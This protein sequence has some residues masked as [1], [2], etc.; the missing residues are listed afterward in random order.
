[1]SL[2][3]ASQNRVSNFTFTNSRS[4]GGGIGAGSVVITSIIITDSNFNNLD[5]TA[6]ATTN[7]YIRI[8]GT[9]FSSSANVFVS[10]SKV[11]SNNVTYVNSTELRVALPTASGYGNTNIFVFNPDNSGAIW[12]PGLLISGTPDF[13]QQSY[14]TS[15]PLSVS[16]QLLATGDVPLTY[17]LQSGSTLPAGL[18]ISSSG[19][20]S[21]S[22]VDGVYQFTVVVSDA[23]LQS[24]QSTITLTVTSTDE[25]FNRTVLAINADTD[26]FVRDASNNNF[27]ITVNGDTKPY[28]FSPYNTNWSNLFDGTG[29][30]LSIAANSSINL[31]TGDFTVEAWI[32]A[33]VATQQQYGC[34]LANHV[35]NGWYVAFN[36]SNQI[37]WSNHTTVAATSST[38][39]TPFKWI[40]VAVTRSGTSLKIFQDGVEVASATNSTAYGDSAAALLVGQNGTGN[41]FTGYVSNAR[42]LKGT[43]LYTSAFTPPAQQLTAITNTSV[44]TCQSNR[45]IDNSTNNLAITKYGDTKVTTFGPF[46]ETDTTTGSGYFDGTGDY[47]TLLNNSAFDLGSGDATIEA[48]IY[49]TTSGQTCG[50]FDKRSSGANYSQFPQI[51]LTSGAFIAYVSYTGSS[52]AGTIN[53]AT[54]T[55]N[56][57]THVAFVRNGNTWTLYVNGSVSGTPFTAAGSVYTSTDSLVIGAS[58][59]AG[60]NPFTGYITNARIIKGTAVYTSAFTPP[61]APLTVIANTSLLTLQNRQPVNNHTFIDQSG[62]N[63]I[64]TKSG[65][66]SQGS[67]SPYSPAG[68]SNYFDGSGDYLTTSSATLMDVTSASQTFTIETWIYP[69]GINT[70]GP[71]NYRFTSI[72]SKGVV[73]LSFGYTSTG[74]LRWYT[75]NG[76][77]NYINSPSGT[78]QNNTWQHVAI[79]SNSGAITLYVNGV[80][81]ATGSLVA[82]NGGTGVSPKIGAGD[83]AAAADFLKGY[84]SNLRVTSSAVYTSAF[85]PSI[86]PLTAITNTS[87][88]TCQSNRLID[89]STNNF[90]LTRNGDVR[91]ANFSPF[92]P[93]AIYS[94]TTHGGSAYFDGSDYLQT[95]STDSGLIRTGPF[96]IE[97]WVYPLS[98]NTNLLSRFYWQTGDNGGWTLSTNSSGFVTFSYSTGA[99]N[100]LG[101]VTATTN[102]VVI[103]QW[104]HIAVTRDT[105]NTLRIFVNGNS[106][107]TPITLAQ[108]LDTVAVQQ[109]AVQS[110]TFRVAVSG[111]GDGALS[112]YYTGYISSVKIQTGVAKYTANSIPALQTFSNESGIN[113]LSNMNTI[114]IFDN[115]SRN[116]IETVGDAKI[117]TDIKKYG[118]GS[119]YFD[120]TGD[121]LVLTGNVDNFVFGVGDFTIEFWLYLNANQ[122]SIVYDQRASGAQGLYPELYINTNSIRFYTNSADRIVGATLNNQQWY[123][124]ALA[125]SG[126][127]TKLFVNG[128]QSGSTYTDSNNYINGTNR[129]V[130]GASASSLGSDP[131]NGYIDD[132]R[133]TKGVARYTTNFNA[134]TSTFLTQ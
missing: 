17:Q 126:T 60:V 59:T 94:P 11:I 90:T 110:R 31:G 15:T 7:S 38:A 100:T 118:T 85:T 39:I 66:P 134:P 115:S 45:L 131:F 113:Y 114:G 88:L 83:T 104:N 34:I 125:R 61:T 89:N 43:A 91:V 73:Y 3:T 23:Q 14:T 53:G 111:L 121:Y 67:F 48:W 98:L 128:T 47:L 22:T 51:A 25:Y 120:G 106:A 69:S 56:A 41:Y 108:S 18:T 26:T 101:G 12:A 84:V 46:T 65:N 28:A 79:V 123:H 116:F 9:G 72:L 74:V 81:V 102:P 19:L 1:M 107:V 54:P 63:N 62:L 13:L 10:G 35:T 20:I 80:S 44:L 99:W 117:R 5:D 40:H 50:I 130:I 27:A 129:P 76:S 68:W 42:V 16:V 97:L 86:A 93:S 70:S 112:G 21:G 2:K 33:T 4:G 133:I 109:A 82:P 52:W 58:T 49:P 75:Y 57:W 30:Y 24:F 36:A 64:V 105:S 87:L 92:K 78:I 96:T 103:N 29:D 6:V 8:V 77:E 132:L 119:M 37:Y 71:E 127:A 32:Y 124:I 95:N 122:T 55:V